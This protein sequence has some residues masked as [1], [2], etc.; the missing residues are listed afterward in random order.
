MLQNK[1]FLPQKEMP[2][3]AKT[4]EKTKTMQVSDS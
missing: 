2:T 4:K 3:N 1:E